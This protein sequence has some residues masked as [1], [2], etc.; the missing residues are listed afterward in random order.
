MCIYVYICVYVYMCIYVYLL[1]VIYIAFI[2]AKCGKGAPAAGSRRP[3]VGARFQKTFAV[4]VMHM[5]DVCDVC[6]ISFWHADVC[7]AYVRATQDIYAR[8]I[9]VYN[10]CEYMY[11]CYMCIYVYMCIRICVYM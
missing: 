6:D 2:G 7:C 9:Y 8:Y 1:Y 10:I 11:I 4:C 3:G 5:C